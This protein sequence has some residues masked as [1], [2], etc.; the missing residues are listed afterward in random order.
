[1]SRP[2]NLQHKMPID[3][4]QL[5]ADFIADLRPVFERE[6]RRAILSPTAIPFSL[7]IQEL[8]GA[9]FRTLKRA[10]MASGVALAIGHS[11]LFS[12]N[13]F[14]TQANQWAGAQAL[15]IANKTAQTSRDLSTAA[16]Y[17]VMRGSPANRDAKLALALAPIFMA[18]SRIQNIAITE[19]TR[20]LSAGE[21]A[22]V[23][24]FPTSGER[25]ERGEADRLVAI[26]QTRDDQRVCSI[27]WPFDGRGVEVWGRQFPDGPPAHPRCRCERR[28]ITAR[29][30]A[31]QRRA[32]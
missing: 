6:Y 25:G 11:I 23:L 1:M 16:V 27:C 2:S 19:T 18:D 31:E 32:A 10:F 24:Y 29:Q 8:A 28:W 13:V 12:S 21:N 4:Y 14:D 9:A 20:A 22:A 26:W 30:W 3:R 7:F 15:A 17:E 5:E